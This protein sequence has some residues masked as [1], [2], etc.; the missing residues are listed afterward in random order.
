MEKAIRV[1][2]ISK[3]D[4]KGKKV[5]AK[6]D[7]GILRFLRSFFLAAEENDSAKDAMQPEEQ[8]KG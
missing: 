7:R 6:H 3:A 8:V 1:Q 5:S 4:G 2:Q